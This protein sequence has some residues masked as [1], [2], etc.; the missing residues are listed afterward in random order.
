MTIEVSEAGPE[1]APAVVLLHGAGT[2]GWIWERQVAGLAADFRVLVPD[3]P[4]HGRSNGRPWVSFAD[5]AALVAGL[6]AERVPGGRAQVVGLSLGGYVGMH[7]AVEHPERVAGLTV[8]GIN[9]LPFANA[10]WIR[11]LG[12][13]MTPMMRWE[14][15]LRAN[16]R[17]LKVSEAEYAGYRASALQM[18][19]GAVRRVTEE[20]LAFRIPDGAGSVACPVLAVAGGN[21]VESVRRSLPEIAAAFPSGEARLV[22]GVGHAWNGERPELF[23]GLV[24]ARIA[25]APL[26]EEL[27]PV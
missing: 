17:T 9:V 5:T 25:G 15:V 27:L 8:S 10:A 16:A 23:T 1:G 6:L 12:R 21:E 22:P 19:K 3:L 18:D 24:R 4:G 14:P 20:A 26:P 11:L 2:S 7:L 13:M